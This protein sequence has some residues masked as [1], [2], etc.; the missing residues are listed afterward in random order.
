ML[1]A[2]L[3]PRK[4]MNDVSPRSKMGAEVV[5]TEGCLMTR[6]DEWMEDVKAK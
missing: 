4:K 1:S 2:G 3:L 5:E 6:E